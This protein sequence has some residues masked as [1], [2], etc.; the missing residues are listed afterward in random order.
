MSLLTIA[1]ISTVRYLSYSRDLA[2]PWALTQATG[3]GLRRLITISTDH[4][5]LTL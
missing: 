3:T 5:P 1:I 4:Y 2:W